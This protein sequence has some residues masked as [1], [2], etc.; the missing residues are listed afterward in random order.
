M[1]CGQL[2]QTNNMKFG[3][4]LLR[5]Q[6]ASWAEHYVNYKALKK[7]LKTE[8]AKGESMSKW[9]HFQVICRSTLL[10]SQ[11]FCFISHCV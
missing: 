9:S 1:K 4:K 5:R 2:A 6:L 8:M 7:I 10:L 3:K 11:Q